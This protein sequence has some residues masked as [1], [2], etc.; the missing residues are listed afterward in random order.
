MHY[1]NLFLLGLVTLSV[2]ACNGDSSPI[3]NLKAPGKIGGTI[4]GGSGGACGGPSFD[5]QVLPIMKA[6]CTSCHNNPGLG[7]WSDYNSVKGA[8]SSKGLVD[9]I[10]LG[11]TPSG[12]PKGG[13]K[14]P[15]PQIATIEQ[16]VAA[17]MP[18]VATACDGDN[19][20]VPPSDD[21]P[22][23]PTRDNAVKGEKIYLTTCFGCHNS[24]DL[25]AIPT[26]IGQ[27]KDYLITQLKAYKGDERTDIT[28][29][30]IMNSMAKGLDEQQIKDIAE[31]LSNRYE[32]ARPVKVS[33]TVSYT[34]AEGK[35]VLFKG[36]VDEGKAIV[37]ERTCFQCHSSAEGTSFAKI[38]G[39]NAQYLFSTLRAFRD[40]KR[41]ATMMAGFVAGMTDETIADIAVYLN[42][43]NRC[44]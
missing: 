38:K 16:W 40:A 30:G 33:D 10:K 4:G 31:H 41:P 26:I 12:M 5:A 9:K 3:D 19:T 44:E 24:E 37:E 6:S 27:P 18:K 29:G 17:G 1:K 21:T 32:C 11:G 43:I 39:Q 36:S 28:M 13:S 42:S 15:D 2:I 8:V 20:P 22:S 34:D 23:E 35:D 25:I 7:N 14:L